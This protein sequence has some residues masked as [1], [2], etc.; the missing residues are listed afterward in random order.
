MN[1]KKVIGDGKF[2]TGA[3]Y[4][5]FCRT[6]PA[7]MEEWDN[8]MKNMADLGYRVVHGFAE[9]HQIEYEKGKFDFSKVDHMVECAARHGITA[10][11]NVATMNNV[12]FYSPRW[13]MEEYRGT[14]RGYVDAEGQSQYEGQFRVPCIDDPIYQAY[15]RRYLAEVA[16]HFADDKRVG[17]YVIWG[18]PF[19]FRPGKENKVAICYCEH[20]VAKFRNWLKERYQTI[21]ALNKAW[22]TEGPADYIDF[23]QLFPPTASSR[24]QGGFVSWEDWR[25]FME[26]NLADHIKAANRIFKENG[27][28][29]PT[30]VEMLTGIHNNIDSWKLAECS[31]IVGTSCFG[32]PGRMTALYMGMADSM[33]KALGKTTFV[34]EATGG[35]VKYLPPNTPTVNEI[36]STLLQRAGYGVRGLMYWC[37]RPRLSDVEGNDFGMVKSNGKV[38][39]KTKEVG[40]LAEKVYQNSERYS[41]S[42]RKSDVAIFSS[43]HINHLMDSEYMTDNYLNAL[44]GA[45]FMMTDLH[46]NSDFICEKEILKGSLRK[47]KALIMPCSYVISDDCA[48]KIEEFVANGGH[49]IADYILAEKRPGGVCYYDWPGAGFDKVF[50]IERDDVL[51]I[52]HPV[53]LKENTAGIRLKSVMELISCTTASVLEEYQ[54]GQPVITSNQYG[55]GN[56]VYFAGQF[57]SGYYEG[58]IPAMRNKIKDFLKQA[59]VEP[60]TVLES[61][62]QENQSQLV[63]SAMYDISD[64]QMSIL[65]ITNAGYETVADTVILPLDAKWKLLDENQKAEILCEDGINKVKFTLEEWESLMIYRES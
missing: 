3:M 59:G 45:N 53:L 6:L 28:M 63:T 41:S 21:E 19:L 51:Y 1:D 22:S 56:A 18:E 50:G 42:I 7:P 23:C 49:V 13:L 60:Y 16:K 8:D 12:G 57:F 54:P 55:E 11:V 25:E 27:A 20:T 62:D 30:I 46:I 40:S 38:L 37:W 24:Q 64:Q 4:A 44:M 9:W 34:V 39:P 26:T 47:Y 65:T 17:G 48:K 29:Q 33:A 61:A 58:P 10:I 52:D 35:S 2:M 15:A 31:D 32:R 14:G 36:K 5:P 43:Q